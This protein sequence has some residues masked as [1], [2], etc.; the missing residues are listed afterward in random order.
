MAS[1]IVFSI[2][3][4]GAGSTARQL[5]FARGTSPSWDTDNA[6][7]ES[8]WSQMPGEIESSVSF[9]DGSSSIG[10]LTLELF[11]SAKAQQGQTIASMLYNQTRVSVGTLEQDENETDTA[12]QLNSSATGLANTHISLGREVIK[13]NVH[14]GS[15]LYTG[16]TRGAWGT[17][18]T[19][20]SASDFSEVFEA[21]KGPV[22]RYRKVTLFRVD[23]DSATSYSDLEQL[24]VF[25]IYTITAPS[26]ELIRIECDSL[27]SIFERGTIINNLWRSPVERVTTTVVTNG[28]DITALKIQ[29]R[30]DRLRATPATATVAIDGQAVIK[31]VFE[32]G[33]STY[34]K[35][36]IFESDIVRTLDS[37]P[38]SQTLPDDPKE[39]WEVFHCSGDDSDIDALPLSANLLTLL[40]QVLTTTNTGTNGAYDLGIEDLGLAISADLIDISGIE[41][42]R[43]NFGRLLDQELLVLGLSGEPLEV[44]SFFKEALVPYGIVICDRNGKLG[45]AE[46]L[47]N[48]P[49][50]AAVSEITD[51]LGPASKP[52][53]EAPAQSRR[54]DLS[55]DAIAVSFKMVPG[56]Q[57]VVDTL[58]DGE[59]RRITI[60]GADTP[61]ALSLRFIKSRRDVLSILLPYLQRFHDDI[62]QITLTVLRTREAD[63]KL[64]DLISLTHTKIYSALNG[65]KGVT[66]ELCLV[67]SRVL[68]LAEN[69]LTVTLLDVGAIYTNTALIAPAAVVESGASGTTIPV[70]EDFADGGFQSG[71]LSAFPKDASSFT[72]GDNLQHCD[73]NGTFI[74][75]VKI[76][77]IATSPSVI[78]V[79][80]TPSPLPAAGDILR[81][82]SYDG[83]LSAAKDRFAFIADTNGTLGSSSDAGKEYSR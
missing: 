5:Y 81:L 39:A 53:R 4:L 41:E 2:E 47:D 67:T 28:E 77:A 50:A 8:C 54:M 74:Q 18:A 9:L 24:G 20:H 42:T 49:D 62:P 32:T 71:D 37:F 29:D 3:G 36:G 19:A 69:T 11:A 38:R 10:G 63:L 83:N 82:Q 34:F 22:L 33:S 15:G 75:N 35:E 30:Q 14:A 55:M 56:F 46:L 1:D 7:V 79:K 57:P 65:V 17:T 73:G 31:P 43:A 70:A 44:F 80:T 72:V 68:S 12:I 16:C 78:T 25:V 6:W 23:L 48:D 59:R 64:G 13:L 76:V 26:P 40:L 58:V 27:L 51:I 21:I 66:G 45:V 60:Y 52:A 61:R